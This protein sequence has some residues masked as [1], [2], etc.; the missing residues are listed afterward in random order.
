MIVSERELSISST[1]TLLIIILI[2]LIPFFIN[3]PTTRSASR[4]DETSRFTTTIASSANE[5]E[6][7]N[8]F[9][10]PAGLSTIIKSKSLF[11]LSIKEFIISVSKFSNDNDLQEGN[12]LKPAILLSFTNTC[13]IVQR[14]S[15]TS[16]KS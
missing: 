16:F 13:S 9:S 8:P 2:V 1:F 14:P 3:N 7:S 15:T 5:A 4:K 10:T 11:N 12:K 6:Y